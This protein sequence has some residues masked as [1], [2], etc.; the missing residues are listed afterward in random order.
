MLSLE[1]F[2]Y[3]TFDP[4]DRL[5]VARLPVCELHDGTKHDQWLDVDLAPVQNSEK[6]VRLYRIKSIPA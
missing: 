1:L 4:D 6:E 2:D 3:D 5:G